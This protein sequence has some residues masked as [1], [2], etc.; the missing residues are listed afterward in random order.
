M[1]SPTPYDNA[2]FTMYNVKL[3]RQKKWPLTFT[4]AGLSSKGQFRMWWAPASSSSQNGEVESGHQQSTVEG[5]QVLLRWAWLSRGIF[6]QDSSGWSSTKSSWCEEAEVF[7]RE[8][9]CIIFCYTYLSKTHVG[10][11]RNQQAEQK[12]E[13]ESS[14][15]LSPV[16]GKEVPL[17]WTWLS[18]GI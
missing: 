2:T 15:H 16:E 11:A 12:E 8:L 18:R 17:C 7:R 9:F 4:F 10:E 6:E 14:H 3:N 1:P 13:G 5:S